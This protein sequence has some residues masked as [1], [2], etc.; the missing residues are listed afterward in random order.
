[1]LSIENLTVSYDRVPAVV[2]VELEIKKGEVLVIL[3]AN[4][5]GKT[6]IIKSIMGL[7]K[8]TDGS[9]VFGAEHKLHK[10]K[11]HM[12]HR[13]GISWVPE[14][15][16]IWG[17]LSVLDNLRM[18]AFIVA[19]KKEI[20]RRL[21][22]T[23]DLFPILKD[24]KKQ[25]GSLLSGGEQQQLAIARCLMSDPQLILMDEP[26][27]G[28]APIAVDHVFDIVQGIKQR[29]ISVLMA[30]QNA[31]KALQVA[32]NV[33]ILE[34]GRIVDRGLPADIAARDVVRELFLGNQG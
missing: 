9:I 11:S 10:L 24:K 34:T 22:A 3:G 32:D 25:L 20:E 7:L 13:L 21:Q 5:A 27:L 17:T 31:R 28:L 18:G 16:E 4:G 6:T 12:I 2:G 15:R 1:M 14:G 26:S 23:F 33:H 19:E 8:L 29:G 30:E